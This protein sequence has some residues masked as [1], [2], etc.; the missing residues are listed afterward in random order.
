MATRTLTDHDLLTMQRRGQ[1]I[2]EACNTGDLPGHQF[3]GNQF[4][5]ERLHE[6]AMKKDTFTKGEKVSV[7]FHH[8]EHGFSHGTVEGVSHASQSARIRMKG[9]AGDYVAHHKFGSIYKYNGP[10]EAAPIEAKKASLQSVLDKVNK[11]N[12][13]EGGWG[14]EHKVPAEFASYRSKK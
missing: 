1:A 4:T 9:A 3:H 13:P 12:E 5:I 11:K 7:F 6:G 8:G 14:D 10:K 2:V